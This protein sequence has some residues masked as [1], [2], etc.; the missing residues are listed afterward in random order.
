MNPLGV[1]LRSFAAAMDRLGIPYLIGGSVASSARGIVRMT[2]DIDVVA[3]IAAFQTERLARELGREWYAEPEQMRDAIAARRAFN[4]IHI[5]LGNKVDIFPATE[6]FHLCQLERA[7][8]K[9][10]V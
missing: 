10:V 9:S 5:P 3:S 4:V 6:D 7:D 2:Y 8:R 1:T